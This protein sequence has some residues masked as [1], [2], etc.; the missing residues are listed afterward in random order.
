MLFIRIILPVILMVCCISCNMQNKAAVASPPGYDLAQPEKF[1]MP[2]SLLEISGISFRKGNSDTIFAIQDEE[3]KVFR[4]T[5]QNKKQTHARFAKNGDYEDIA[6]LNEQV[7][8]LKSNGELF[9]F[10]FSQMNN[11]DA[12]QVKAWK[13]L[14]P[15]GEYEGLYGDEATG[16]IYL[17]CKDCETDNKQ[18]TVTGY[19]L[20]GTDSLRQTGQFTIDMTAAKTGGGKIKKGFRPSALA[21]NPITREWFVISAANQLLVVTDDNWHIKET[22]HL[23]SG[24]FNQPEGIAFDK[25]GNLYISNEGDELTDGNILKFTRK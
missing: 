4:L 18:K 20:S 9:S 5:W 17:L 11:E 23:D 21:Y 24:I 2:S 8:V 25:A 7:L 6:I 1:K 14:V 13:H 15:P 22:Y 12:E 19:I 16:N 10:P 3:G